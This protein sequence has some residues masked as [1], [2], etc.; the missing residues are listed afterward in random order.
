V[1]SLRVASFN[2]RNGR[3]LDG[4]H[5]WPFRR[6]ATAQ[7]LAALDADVV[8]LQEVYRFQERFLL[9]AVQGYR[10]TGDPR[11]RWGERCPVLWRP[12]R[13]AAEQSTTCWFAD[14][15]G[16]AGARLPGASFPRV[17]TLTVC[18]ATDGGARF[19]FANLHLDERHASNRVRSAEMLLGWL[20]RDIPWV[21]VGD[22][23]EAPGGPALDVLRAA[24]FRSALADDAPG[25]AHDFRGGSDGP[26]I[27]HVLV[28]PEW[29]IVSAAVEV[30]AGGRLPSDHWPVVADLRLGR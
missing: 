18:T 23:N 2:I 8:G 20:D 5:A 6:R 3:A 17:A 19:G 26:R 27:D 12:D 15:P 4:V 16:R 30:A 25:T 13:L 9:K 21:V 11:S 22:F 28:G 10:A 14:D 7:A 24:G 29:D 1:T